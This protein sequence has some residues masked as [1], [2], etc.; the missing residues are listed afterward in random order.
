MKNDFIILAGKMSLVH[1][2]KMSKDLLFLDRLD[3]DLDETSL[4]CKKVAVVVNEGYLLLVPIFSLPRQTLQRI[5]RISD[6]MNVYSYHEL[7]WCLDVR[8]KI[9]FEYTLLQCLEDA[10]SQTTSAAFV[11]LYSN[12]MFRKLYYPAVLTEAM[13]VDRFN[14]KQNPLQRLYNP[15]VET[16]A[17]SFG[18]HSLANLVIYFDQAGSMCSCFDSHLDVVGIG[19]G[20]EA[21]NRLMGAIYE[22][23][24]RRVSAE[25][26]DTL[27]SSTLNDM[28]EFAMAPHQLFGSPPA[29]N[30][31][32]FPAY[33]PGN[34][35]TWLK[36]RALC[37]DRDVWLPAAMVCYLDSQLEKLSFN[38]NSNGCALGNSR[39]EASYY[40]LLELIERDALLL[41]WYTQ[42]SPPKLRLE[43]MADSKLIDIERQFLN[44]GYRLHLFDITTDIGIP[45]VLSVLEGLA[46][47]KMAAFFT[48]GAHPDPSVALDNAVSEAYSLF[49][50]CEQNYQ[51]Y[52][53]QGSIPNISNIQQYFEYARPENK[54]KL[55]FIF[56]NG[57][58]QTIESFISR[59]SG[60][61]GIVDSYGYLINQLEKHGYYPV[62]VE[63]TPDYLRDLGLHWVRGYVPGLINLVFGQKPVFVCA[64]R[65]AKAARSTGWVRNVQIGF[66]PDLHPLG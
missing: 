36:G 61:Q 39:R 4:A 46:P 52:R 27:V 66:Y 35:I 60:W 40:A 57:K 23:L 21:H 30:P 62:C 13:M 65:V 58:N 41:T 47:D 43:S 19:R 29:D 6:R 25:L 14:L 50:M 42:S 45:V 37:G 64:D 24:E 17:Q 15:K 3:D 22:Y 31:V 12:G 38:T 59:Y 2:F 34:P 5:S 16:I 44:C 32:L 33:S 26:P 49:S 54:P 56:A 48:A 10:D 51:R 11:Y 55:E 18:Q 63:H 53:D 1:G 8:L 28:P 7:Q 9:L 20:R